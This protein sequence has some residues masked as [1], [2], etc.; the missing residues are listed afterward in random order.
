MIVATMKSLNVWI[1]GFFLYADRGG[2]K[3]GNVFMVWIVY[4]VQWLVYKPAITDFLEDACPEDLQQMNTAMMV[5]EIWMFLALVC[6]ILDSWSGNL[7]ETAD[8]SRPLNE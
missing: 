3:L 8:E 2:I 5:T 6:S 7:G 4:L 1:L